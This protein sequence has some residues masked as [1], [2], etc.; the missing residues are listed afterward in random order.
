MTMLSI[1][2]NICSVDLEEKDI[3]AH[4]KD[5]LHQSNKKII[6]Y[7]KDDENKN[8]QSLIKTWLDSLKSGS[9]E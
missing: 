4:I 5:A 6:L 8:G 7:S 3:D 1:S 9:F 2:C